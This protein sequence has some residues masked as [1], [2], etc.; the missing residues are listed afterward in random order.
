M[1]RQLL[2]VGLVFLFALP[3][4]AADFGLTELDVRAGESIGGFPNW[5]ERLML[6]WMNRARVDPQLEMRACGA[7]CGE[8]ACY[9]PMPPL[10]WTTALN[11]AARFHADE[12]QKQSYFSHTSK[13]RIVTG[14]D[15]LYPAGCDGSAACA[16]TGGIASCP[17]G[18]CSSW[19]Q[20]VALFGTRGAGEIIARGKDP[21]Q[22]VYLWLFERSDSTACAFSM[23]NGHR[24][25]ILTH[26]GGAGLGYNDEDRTAVGDFGSGPAPY[27]IPSGSHY[28]RQAKT[29]EFWANWFDVKAPKS[30]AVV[31]NGQCN[32]MSLRRGTGTN[33]SWSASSTSV[34]SGCHRYYFSFIDGDGREVTYPATGSLGV[35][36][37]NWNS[38]RLSASCDTAPAPAPT[39]PARR[40]AAGRG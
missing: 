20:R 13:C 22:S 10:T 5:G 15:S 39:I 31:I 25:L 17:D 27:R 19:T 24:W 28:P 38:S 8:A 3:A 33:G 40:R 23:R 26:K 35:G 32:A 12:M 36:C 14:I 1:F 2:G 4:A 21:G 9:K 30:A 37:E 6:T 11:R 34:A 7:A 18:D 16:C 29:V